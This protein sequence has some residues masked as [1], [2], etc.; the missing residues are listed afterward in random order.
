MR[1]HLTALDDSARRLGVPRDSLFG[2]I[3]ALLAEQDALRRRTDRL[4]RSLASA[5]TT[6]QLLQR[7]F[8]V[9]GVRVLAAQ[10]EAPSVDALRYVGDAVR[11]SLASGVAVLGTVIDQRPQFIAIVTPDLTSR[12]PHAGNILRKVAS[13]AG[14]GGGGRADMAQGGG[15]DAGKLEEALRIVPELVREM[16]AAK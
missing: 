8:D 12:G 13:V 6:D 9:D 11:K 7:A 14:G 15:K 10:V 3:D 4:E 1:R 2:R 5:P 16:L